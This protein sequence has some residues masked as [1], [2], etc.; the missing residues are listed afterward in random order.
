MKTL[1]SDNNLNI[2]AQLI[3]EKNLEHHAGFLCAQHLAYWVFHIM[4]V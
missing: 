4:F 3:E 1:N 2:D